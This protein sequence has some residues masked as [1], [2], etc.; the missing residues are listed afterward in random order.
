MQNLPDLEEA[1]AP[2]AVLVLKRWNSWVQV[3]DPS[4]GDTQWVCLSETPF[5]PVAASR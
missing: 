3:Y 5:V 1:P 2:G 4:T